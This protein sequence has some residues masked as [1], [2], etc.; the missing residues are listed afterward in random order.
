LRAPG[1]NDRQAW[2]LEKIFE[3][4]EQVWRAVIEE[5]KMPDIEVIV[6]TACLPEQVFGKS[7]GGSTMIEP[8]RRIAERVR[9]G[10]HVL[11]ERSSHR[12]LIA[13]DSDLIVALIRQLLGREP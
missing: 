5:K 11:A 9:R 4:S 1:G 13:N 3:S 12:T 6:V 2:E 10:R 7:V 8:H